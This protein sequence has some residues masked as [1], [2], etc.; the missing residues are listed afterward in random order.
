[1]GWLAVAGGLAGLVVIGVDGSVLWFVAAAALLAA[2]TVVRRR[3]PT[4]RLA[5]WFALMT[6]LLAV[7]FAIPNLLAWASDAHASDRQVVGLSFG[8]GLVNALTTVVAMRILVLFPDG[9]FLGRLDRGVLRGTWLLLLLPWIVVLFAE[10]IALPEFIDAEP[11]TNPFATSWAFLSPGAV[12]VLYGVLTLMGLVGAG[13]LV[14]RY[15]YAGSS[16]RRS[17][18]WLILPA[19]VGGAFGVFAVL[20]NLSDEALGVGMLAMVVALGVAI[21]LGLLRP[22]GIDVDEALRRS[23]VYGVLVVAV[24]GLYAATSAFVAI[25]VGGGV[26]VGWA[27]VL[28]VVAMLALQP[29]RAALERWTR[30]WLFGAPPD[31]RRVILGLGE[32]LANTYDVETLLN[33]IGAALEEGL[34]VEW[35]RVRVVA[36]DRDGPG[37]PSLR[38]PI[39]LDGETVGVIEC[40]P[41]RAGKLDDEDEAIVTAL[42][43][44]AALAVHNARLTALVEERNAELAASRSRLVRA[45]EDERRRIEQNIHDGAQQDLVALIGQAGFVR[46]RLLT[47]SEALSSDVVDEVEALQTGLQRVLGEVRDLAAGI[48]PSLLRDRGLVVAIEGLA[49][50]HPLPVTVRA[51]PELRSLRLPAEVE[52]AGYYVVAE[53]L[54]NGLKHADASHMAVDLARANGTLSIHVS[55]DGRGFD[56]SPSPGS[57][58]G[59]L[60]E[61]VAAVG[62][63]LRVVSRPGRGTAVHVDLA[64]ASSESAT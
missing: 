12:D 49:A 45:Q 19:I 14:R 52:G 4:L 48:H 60:S 62:G 16:T 31:P 24:A 25:T 33:Q 2:A 21:T 30:R 11:V 43:G 26:S 57:G 40:G 58:L 55:D 28:T 54:A 29:A 18:R 41:K 37:P 61:R 5:G 17:I 39:E 27:V 22:T 1:M 63:E 51:E 23:V 44:Q 50:R 35:A 20:V 53:S 47:T 32:W 9:E 6:G 56:V 64:A 8:Y 46:R 36:D 42:A 59:N 3:R 13:L 34:G 15:R 10:R 38:V 7:G